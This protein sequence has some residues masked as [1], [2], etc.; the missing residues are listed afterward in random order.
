VP[1]SAS[2][3]QRSCSARTHAVFAIHAIRLVLDLE[4]ALRGEQLK[5]PIDV[6]VSNTDC[7][8]AATSA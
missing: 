5:A 8:R 4:A 3:W 2:R 7:L 6:Y 1:E